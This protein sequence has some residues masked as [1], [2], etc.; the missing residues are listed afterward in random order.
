MRYSVFSVA[1]ASSFVLGNR[2][3][4]FKLNKLLSMYHIKYSFLRTCNLLTLSPRVD[5]VN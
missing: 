2:N 4:I 5:R 1:F 3:Y